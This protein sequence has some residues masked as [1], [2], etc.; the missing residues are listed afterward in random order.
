MNPDDVS[1][2]PSRLPDVVYQDARQVAS[3]L[4]ED[5]NGLPMVDVPKQLAPTAQI[6]G[7][8]N[9]RR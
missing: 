7:K 4:N 3:P 2:E 6:N 5:E 9:K 1:T 8:R